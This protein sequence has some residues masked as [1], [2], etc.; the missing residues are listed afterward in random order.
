MLRTERRSW[1]FWTFNS[2]KNLWTLS[3]SFDN[4]YLEN[5]IEVS[6]IAL[7]IW[8]FFKH[9]VL[10]VKVVRVYRKENFDFMYNTLCRIGWLK[11]STWLLDI[12][13][14]QQDLWFWVFPRLILLGNRKAKDITILA[15]FSIHDPDNFTC[16]YHSMLA[17]CASCCDIPLRFLVLVIKFLGISFQLLVSN[18]KDVNRAWISTNGTHWWAL[19]RSSLNIHHWR[20]RPFSY[21]FM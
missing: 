7:Y 18:Y 5:K 6:I 2:F 1:I 10:A 19:S 14:L 17:S 16:S 8:K 15:I 11:V 9:P 4:N 3:K 13:C 12:I 20:M 21:S